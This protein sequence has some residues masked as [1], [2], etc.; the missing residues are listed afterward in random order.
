M[1]GI[2]VAW[3]QDY[4]FRKTILYIYMCGCGCVDVYVHLCVCMYIY[5]YY[6]SVCV[7][8]C[9]YIYIC[10]ILILSLCLLFI[11]LCIS[12]LIL[13]A[14]RHIS[15]PLF[16]K[17]IWNR[18]NIQDGASFCNSLQSLAIDCIYKE[19]HLGCLHWFCMRFWL[20]CFKRSH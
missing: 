14:L 5:I 3:N 20:F 19:F 1:N 7:C 15:L 9:V 18:A 12:Y 8:V 4:D 13:C 6:I 17:C 2:R 11:V 16:R 10:I